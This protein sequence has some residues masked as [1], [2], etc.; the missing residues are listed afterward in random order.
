LEQS[1]TGGL[2]KETYVILK[3]RGGK[4]GFS[5]YE[6]K[7]KIAYV[8]PTFPATSVQ[9]QLGAFEFSGLNQGEPLYPW[10]SLDLAQLSLLNQPYS[11]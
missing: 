5:E 1:A 2:K 9:I 4:N 7:Q 3:L 11:I 10:R 6:V 8:D